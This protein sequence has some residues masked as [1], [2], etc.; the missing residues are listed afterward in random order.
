M[1][2]IIGIDPGVTGA[3]AM[4][5]PSGKIIDIHDLPTLEHKVGKRTQRTLNAYGLA[6]TIAKWSEFTPMM[7]WVEQSQIRGGSGRAPGATSCF[8]TGRTFGTIEG[9]IAALGVPVQYVHP[10]TWKTA[11]RLVGKTKDDSRTRA[12]EI[13]PEYTTHLARKKDH[14]RAEAILIA[15]YGRVQS[16]LATPMVAV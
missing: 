5:S 1:T 9:I 4:I 6:R 7:I 11:H 3:M 16:Q 14:N 15:H 2:Y 8:S 13:Y 10:R 12:L